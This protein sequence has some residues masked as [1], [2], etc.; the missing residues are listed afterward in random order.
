LQYNVESHNLSKGSILE[1][2]D[3]WRALADQQ[4]QNA[5]GVTRLLET[6]AAAR[7]AGAPAEQPTELPARN[8]YDVIERGTMQRRFR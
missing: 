4:L 2:L 8:Y 5:T 7:R 6:E 3:V 1:W